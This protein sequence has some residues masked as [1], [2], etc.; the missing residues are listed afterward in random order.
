MLDIQSADRQATLPS[1]N[2]QTTGTASG[3]ARKLLDGGREVVKRWAADF[4][5]GS[6]AIR[7]VKR[8]I[9]NYRLSQYCSAI[10]HGSM[11]GDES[12]CPGSVADHRAAPIDNR[13]AESHVSNCGSSLA[14]LRGAVARPSGGP[15][16]EP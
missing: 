8:P 6:G 7:S 13:E 1:A 14:G 4:V 16:K 3:P 12:L 2:V 9:H 5:R 10:P 15:V 11:D